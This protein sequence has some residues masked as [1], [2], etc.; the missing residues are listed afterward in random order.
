FKN[1]NIE[2]V[3]GPALGA[4]QMAYEVS[5]HLETENFFT[6]RVDGEMVLRRGFTIE[7][8]TRCLVV[9][10]VVTTG[11]SVKEVIEIIEQCGGVIAGIGSIVDRTGGKMNFGFPFKSVISMDVESWDE[12]ECPICKENKIELIKPGSRKIK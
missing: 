7:K 11:G 12:S 1:D 4:V 5:R 9:E 3:V 6:E 10:D 8:G 2:L